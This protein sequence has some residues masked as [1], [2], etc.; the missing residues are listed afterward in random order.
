LARLRRETFFSLETLNARIRTLLEE[1]NARPMKKLGG[2]TRRELFERFDRPALRPLPSARFEFAEWK[3]VTVN[4][5]YHAE[6]DKHWYSAPYVLVHEE[7]WARATATTVEIFHRGQRVAAHLRSLVPYKHT[8]EPAHMPE[9]HRRHSAGVDAVLAWGA[10]V[11]P[12]T[13]AM[14]RRLIDA[15]PVREQGWRSARGLQRIG[16]KYGAD[17][18]ELA[19]TRALKLG[20]RSY[21]PVAN[22]LALGRESLPLP[23]EEDEER[24]AIVHEN[25]RGPDY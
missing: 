22:I 20:A 8:T 9:A 11:G 4:L 12:M 18:I 21:K 23:G 5:D 14:V 7:L 16:E 10:S 13:E 19:C 2:A 17:R 1:L 6:V 15:N 25:V 24:A 3:Q